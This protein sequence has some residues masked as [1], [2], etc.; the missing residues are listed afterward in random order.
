MRRDKS[1]PVAGSALG[2]HEQI[3]GAW[4]L[5]YQDRNDPTGRPVFGKLLCQQETAVHNRAAKL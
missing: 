3:V 1:E 4:V 5:R 2:E